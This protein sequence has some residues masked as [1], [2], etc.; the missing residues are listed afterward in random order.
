MYPTYYLCF[1]AADKVNKNNCNHDALISANNFKS[2]LPN[3]GL[4]IEPIKKSKKKFPD[5]LVVLL[6]IIPHK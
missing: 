1:N 3:L 2:T 4:R 6:L 5:I